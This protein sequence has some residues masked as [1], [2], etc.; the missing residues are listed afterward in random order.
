M[1]TLKN[2]KR[3]L[4]ISKF[5]ISKINNYQTIMG[6]RKNIQNDDDDYDDS[7]VDTKDDRTS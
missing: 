5:Q 2:Q 7:S 4:S 3:T 6:G 1:K